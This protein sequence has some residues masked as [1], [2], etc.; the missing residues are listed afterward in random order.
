M[1]PAQP[2]S[3]ARVDRERLNGHRG[4]VV[5]FTGLSGSG[6]STLANA[7]EVEL[8][9]RGM[10]TCLLD[11]DNLRQGLN[12]DLGFTEADRVENI[13][14]VGEVARLMMDAGLIVLAA[15]ISPFRRDREMVRERI[16][17]RD[18][19]EVYLATPLEICE[20]RDPKGLYRQARAGQL[21]HMTGLT[22]PYE[23]PES[24]EYRAD[25]ARRSLEEM[26]QDLVRCLAAADR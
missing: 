15:F 18:F 24:P 8:H 1:N 6:K 23:P 20:Q 19:V 7:L 17:A 14:R 21:A 2:F 11:G 16:G 25:G 3:I 10:R 4:K 12:R 13:R 22:S 9:G 5:W 26:V